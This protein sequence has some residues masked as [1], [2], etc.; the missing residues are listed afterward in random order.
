M[1]GLVVCRRAHR[2]RPRRAA[3]ESCCRAGVTNS[4]VSW[5]GTMLSEVMGR[6]GFNGL[7]VVAVL[8]PPDVATY[9]SGVR[10]RSLT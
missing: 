9:P 10:V 6:L 5:T 3:S 2:G 1:G 8:S 4:D 7:K